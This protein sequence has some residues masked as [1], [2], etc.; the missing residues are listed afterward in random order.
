MSRLEKTLEKFD[1]DL[2]V[3][4]VLEIIE[5]EKFNLKQQELNEIEKVKSKFENTYLKVID[6]NSVFGNQL[7]VYKLT[8]FVRSERTIDWDFIYYFNGTRI[9]F[10]KSD[11]FKTDLN[12]NRTGNSFSIEDLNNMT[13]ITE[14][15]FQEYQNTY[16]N[17]SKTL[18]KLIKK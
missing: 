3:K 12:P 7:Q 2:T 5:Q 14:Q 13:V 11:I 9:C 10:S 6:P 4:E 1:K 18:Q 17:I 8:D 16:Q 15:D